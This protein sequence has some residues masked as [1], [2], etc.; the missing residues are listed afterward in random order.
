MIVTL[1]SKLPLR[2]P[3]LRRYHLKSKTEYQMNNKICKSN[4]L[5]ESLTQR[6]T[7][8]KCS[9]VTIPIVFCPYLSPMGFY[10]AF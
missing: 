1:L 5:S 7:K 6:Q 8:T 2:L 9:A 4:Q 3:T 10:Y